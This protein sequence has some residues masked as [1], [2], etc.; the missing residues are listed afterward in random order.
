MP[1]HFL[2]LTRSARQALLIGGIGEPG[3]EETLDSFARGVFTH[4]TQ[5]RGLNAK[6]RPIEIAQQDWTQVSMGTR[7]FAPHRTAPRCNPDF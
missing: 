2:G 3:P 1:P 6:H 7:F 4:L 5:S